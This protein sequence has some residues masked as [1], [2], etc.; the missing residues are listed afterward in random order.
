MYQL[1]ERI[2]TVIERLYYSGCRVKS[3]YNLTLAM[4]IGLTRSKHS[5]QRQADVHAHRQLSTHR[6]D[7][8][9]VGPEPQ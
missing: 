1:Y 6:D 3:F 2:L 4:Y 9:N 5:A 7:A 8:L